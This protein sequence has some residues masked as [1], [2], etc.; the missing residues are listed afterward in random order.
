V[1]KL[2]HIAVLGGLLAGGIIGFVPVK[3]PAAEPAKQAQPAISE[4]ADAALLRMGQTL[5]AADFSFQ[6]QTV[7]VYAEPNGEPL[8]IFHT[9][10]VTMH[11]PNQLL[12]DVTGDDGS[13]KLL[14]DGKTAIVYSA[15]QNK[16]ASIPVPD[17]TIEGMLKEAVGRLGI[18]FPLADF[19]TEAPNKAFLTGVTSGRLVNTVTIDGAPHDHLFFFQPPGIELELWLSK[20]EQ[21]LPRRLIVTY[22]SLPGKPNFI[23][24]FSDWNF[25]IHP[26]DADFAFQP[27]AGATQVE[28]KPVAAA[29]PSAKGKGK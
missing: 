4:E 25:N 9:M 19:L 17:G 8:H 11:R 18:D 6:A 16:Y 5:R 13:S 2:R 12:V 24:L 3:V 10:K 21:A 23:A 29:A 1:V 27:P 20:N 22:R 14:F 7:R 26:S 15:A 28:L